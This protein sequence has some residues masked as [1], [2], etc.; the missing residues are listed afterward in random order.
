MPRPLLQRLVERRIEG[1]AR[2]LVAFDDRIA[3]DGLA[4]ASAWGLTQ[5]AGP[6]QQ[7]GEPA[8]PGRPLLLVSNHPGLVDAAALLSTL[9]DHDVRLLV[10]ARPLFHALPALQ[11]HLISVAPAGAGR[12][13]ALRAAVRHLRGG[14]TL[15]TYPAGRIEPDPAA[16][17]AGAQVAL[18]R[19]SPSVTYLAR[20]VPALTVQ[21]VAVSHVIAPRYRRHW[22]ARQAIDSEDRDAIAAALQVLAARIHDNRPRL[23]IGAPITGGYADTLQSEIQRAMTALLHPTRSGPPL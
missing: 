15:L 22:L 4:S 20:R 12:A 18:A 14:G 17:W 19:W 10:A 21:P 13:H 1:F 6:V 9:A 16:D 5:W 7:C 23:T 3:R 11:A 2:Q 8:S